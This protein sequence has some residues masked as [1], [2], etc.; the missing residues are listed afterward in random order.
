MRWPRVP[1]LP[2][3]QAKHDGEVARCSPSRATQEEFCDHHYPVSR[4]SAPHHRCRTSPPRSLS[5]YAI[6]NESVCLSINL[7]LKTSV[8]LSL[9]RTDLRSIVPSFHRSIVPSFHRSIVVRSAFDAVP[10]MNVSKF[11]PFAG[12]SFIHSSFVRSLFAHSKAPKPKTAKQQ[13]E[14]AKHQTIKPFNHS[15]IPRRSHTVAAAPV[16]S[17]SGMTFRVTVVGVS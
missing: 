8:H 1:R 2:T 17:S 12:H 14:T 10:A 5:T 15:T 11:K 13:N 6:L 4:Y 16:S 9:V 7:S 3:K